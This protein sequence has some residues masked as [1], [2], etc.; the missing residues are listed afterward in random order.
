MFVLIK[1][2]NIYCGA[3]D[4][5]ALWEAEKCMVRWQN[6]IE[7]SEGRKKQYKL[8]C[9]NA[10]IVIKK[11]HKVAVQG[12]AGMCHCTFQTGECITVAFSQGFV[13]VALI[14]S[15]VTTILVMR[16]LEPGSGDSYINDFISPQE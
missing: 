7:K 13:G 8:R 3:Y 9:T 5:I 10:F 11:R 6:W 1:T 2:N 15:A 16:S 14:M 4:C 12:G